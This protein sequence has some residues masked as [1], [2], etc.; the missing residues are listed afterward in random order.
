[1]KIPLFKVLT[2]GKIPQMP[3]REPDNVADPHRNHIPPGPIVLI[4]L[5]TNEMVPH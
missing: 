4:L 5:L 3:V 1:M 2:H